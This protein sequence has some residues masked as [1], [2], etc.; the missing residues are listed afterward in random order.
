MGHKLD[1]CLLHIV[2]LDFDVFETYQP[3]SYAGSINIAPGGLVIG[4]F[5]PFRGILLEQRAL[6]LVNRGNTT[7][8]SR[9]V[10]PGYINFAPSVL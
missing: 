5:T 8:S 10:A 3:G 2:S 6:R 9:G 1:R 4:V 7:Q